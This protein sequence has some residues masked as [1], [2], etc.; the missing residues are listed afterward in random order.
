M[1][2]GVKR[3]LP[4]SQWDQTVLQRVSD[5]KGPP[6]PVIPLRDG[7]N[8]LCQNPFD[9]HNLSQGV[10]LAQIAR[11]DIFNVEGNDW[12]TRLSAGQ[13]GVLLA[14]LR[15]DINK[16]QTG[17]EA[18]LILLIGAMGGGKST[19]AA[20]LHE[21]Y[22]GNC[23]LQ[24]IP[25]I[26]ASE[27]DRYEAD[28]GEVGTASGCSFS[29][30]VFKGADEVFNLIDASKDQ[31]K[32]PV[33]FIGEALF[34]FMQD[35]KIDK[36][37]LSSFIDG[38]VERKVFI[39]FDI[40][41][42]FATSE[43]SPVAQALLEIL[44]E[45][46]IEIE[47]HYVFSIDSHKPEMMAANVFPYKFCRKNGVLRI[48]DPREPV[49]GVIRTSDTRQIPAK[50]KYALFPASAYSWQL[51][52]GDG[53]EPKLD[54]LFLIKQLGALG[55]VHL[56]LLKAIDESCVLRFIPHLGLPGSNEQVNQILQQIIEQ[57]L[58]YNTCSLY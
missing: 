49:I 46:Q 1:V 53:I 28:S 2:A 5:L 38:L 37:A 54:A 8:S 39:I 11:G 36:Q 7:V 58:R 27:L 40:L 17:S 6:M 24:F 14:D 51:M 20:A 29:A 42:C 47:S 35:N 43:A 56:P 3:I 34:V 30:H 32:K 44:S 18:K 16:W 55:L 25:I 50:G 19:A 52:A 26:G 13:T 33:V 41:N 48:H 21:L 45:K 15:I 9:F 31:G 57:T 12:R 4:F 22:K 23:E 10:L